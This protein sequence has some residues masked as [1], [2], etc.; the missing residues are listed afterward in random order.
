MNVGLQL[1]NPVE[2]GGARR[3]AQDGR[4]L[5]QRCDGT[6]SLTHSLAAT[7]QQTGDST[8]VVAAE[9]CP[10]DRIAEHPLD[11]RFERVGRCKRQSGI[12]SKSFVNKTVNRFVA[13]VPY[14]DCQRESSGNISDRQRSATIITSNH[15]KNHERT[16]REPGSE[17]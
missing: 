15:N 16:M 4:R 13:H 11:L 12:L 5:P 14:Q 6:E 7:T 2:F 1:I 3:L 17:Q 10:S 9:S 8:P